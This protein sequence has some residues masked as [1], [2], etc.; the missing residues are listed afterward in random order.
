MKKILVSACL[1]GESCRYDGTS[2]KDEA[3]EELRKRFDLVPFCPEVEGGLKTPRL[4]NEIRFGRV[5][6]KK[7]E[8]V[9]KAFLLG[10]EKA[11][12][13]C[14][15]LNIDVAILKENSPSCGTHKIHDGL[16]DGRLID[17]MGITAKYLSANGIK[18][19][20]ESTMFDFLVEEKEKEDKLHDAYLAREAKKAERK[21]AQEEAEKA[22]EA[23]L[24]EKKAEE[25]KKPYKKSFGAK[26]PYGRK[27]FGDKKPYGKR[28]SFGDKKPYG[29]RKSFGDKPYGE[30]K[31]FSHKK[32][33]GKAKS[34]GSKPHG[35]KRSTGPRKSFKKDQ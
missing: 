12:K 3:I 17:G 9:T 8:D 19:Y 11:L 33:Y 10:A 35:A 7:G 6:N 20:S 16:F 4:P 29:K 23:A 34:F 18:C 31:P 2:K 1:L 27:S 22:K 26:K 14:K 13:I 15:F 21:A 24:E 25:E 30:K 32:P 28:E 5:F